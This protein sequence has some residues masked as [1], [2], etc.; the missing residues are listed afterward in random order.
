MSSQDELYREVANGHAAALERLARAY[1]AEPE[2]RRD[3]LQE[4]HFALWRSFESFDKR[5][6]LRTWVYRV[7]HNAAAS[8]VLRSRRAKRNA[9]ISLEELGEGHEPASSSGQLSLES[10]QLLVQLYAFIH[11]LNPIDRQVIFLY[12]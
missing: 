12:L 9:F 11:E 6:T 4:I 2:Q 8:H 5:C 3:L 10:S 7:A 1:E